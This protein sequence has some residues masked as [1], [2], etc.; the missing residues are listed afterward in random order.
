[1]RLLIW[2]LAGLA[3]LA[4]ATMLSGFLLPKAREG[5][6]GITIA[7]PPDRVLAVIQDVDA[8]P[9][10]RTGIRSITRTPEG[11]VETTTRGERITFTVEEMAEARVRLR[12]TSSAGYDGPWEAALTP[13]ASGTRVD[14]VDKAEIPSAIGRIVARLFF[15]PEAF[16]V[17]YLQALKVRSEG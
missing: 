1:M 11:W 5:R 9:D 12:F 2:S 14:V 16:A 15:D 13:L 17:T 3:F 7:A 4:A 10:W 6:A 8:Q